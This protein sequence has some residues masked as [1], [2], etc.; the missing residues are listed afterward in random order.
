MGAAPCH[1]SPM[2]LSPHST[3]CFPLLLL[4][5]A[6]AVREGGEKSEAARK[7]AEDAFSAY[8]ASRGLKRA[9]LNVAIQRFRAVLSAAMS[10]ILLQDVVLARKHQVEKRLWSLCVS[11]LCCGSIQRF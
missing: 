8:L 11:A 3:L 5:I 10:K 9:Q 6:G 2:S 4:L 1:H 7:V